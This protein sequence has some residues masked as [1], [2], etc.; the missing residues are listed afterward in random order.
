VAIIASGGEIRA[1][2]R[3]R[4]FWLRLLAGVALGHLNA[5]LAVAGTMDLLF[6]ASYVLA[7]VRSAHWVISTEA[8]KTHLFT[9]V[10]LAEPLFVVAVVGLAP[11]TLL[12]SPVALLMALGL[13]T[14]RSDTML[15][16]A[17]AG[18]FIGWPTALAVYGSEMW[19]P[20]IVSA[21]ACA[22]AAMALG[23]WQRCIRHA[24]APSDLH[25]GHPV[26]WWT[27]RTPLEIVSGLF[28]LLAVL[29]VLSVQSTGSTGSHRSPLT[30]WLRLLPGD[31]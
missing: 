29:A 5:A 10:A 25:Q 6:V 31:R 28:A 20:I 17:L 27:A 26:R 3:S 13:R 19:N 30:I 11:L 24:L 18:L 4:R 9:I 1:R 21:A 22:G 23:L 8:L 14:R 12:T 2:L 7:A 15:L 16:G